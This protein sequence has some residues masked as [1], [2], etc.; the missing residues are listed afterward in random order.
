M[1]EAPKTET[2]KPEASLKVT[3]CEPGERPDIIIV[4]DTEDQ[5]EGFRSQVGAVVSR[6]F[7]RQISLAFTNGVMLGCLATVLGTFAMRFI[8]SLFR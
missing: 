5:A 7:R 2:P 4:T 1:T 8:L 3:Q 6:E